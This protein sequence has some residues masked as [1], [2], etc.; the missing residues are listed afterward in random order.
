MQATG[1]RFADINA[2]IDRI[3]GSLLDYFKLLPPDQVSWQPGRYWVSLQIAGVNI[4]AL[5]GTAGALARTRR[6][7]RTVFSQM[8][9]NAT[10]GRGRP[11]SQLRNFLSFAPRNHSL[12]AEL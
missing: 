8:T 2:E 4:S 12:K 5:T 6:P 9:S 11:R 3:T 7:T 1:T 10:C